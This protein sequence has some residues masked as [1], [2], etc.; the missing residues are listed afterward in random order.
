MNM[1]E[2][3]SKM[4]LVTLQ[5]IATAN[6]SRLPDLRAADKLGK[7]RDEIKRRKIEAQK[8]LADIEQAQKEIYSHLFFTRRN[9]AKLMVFK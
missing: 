9:R 5:S 8:T 7:V 4:D 3:Y 1:H 6:I 2:D